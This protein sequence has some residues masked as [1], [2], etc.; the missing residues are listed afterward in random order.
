[1]GHVLGQ[2]RVK[3]ILSFSVKKGRLAHAYLFHGQAGLGKDAMAIMMAKWLNCIKKQDWGCG[4]CLS[5]HQIDR[6]IHNSFHFVIPVPNKPKSMKEDRYREILRENG[7]S[8]IK[9]SYRE[10]GFGPDINTLPIIGIDQIRALKKEVILKLP[11]DGNRVILIS[12]ADKMTISAANSLLKLLEE[13]PKGTLLFLTTAYPD[14]LL[15]TILSRCHVIRFDPIAEKDLA[16]F[17]KRKNQVTEQKANLYAQIAGGSLGKALTIAEGAYDE[18]LNAAVNFFE[19][20]LA[21]DPIEKILAV[22]ELQNGREKTELIEILQILQVWMRDI[23]MAQL[24]FM[25]RILH[26][27]QE[28][29]IQK[30]LQKKPFFHAE[31]AV[32]YVVQSIDFIEKNVYLSLII[33]ALIENIQSCEKN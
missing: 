9:D 13:P 14:R 18:K 30:L 4:E 10:V 16:C 6:I 31:E 22:E 12:H 28:G 17:L 26:K 3:E 11:G 24:G 27:E 8:R 7:L 15:P 20:A 23:Y 19:G 32:K 21:D 33:Y 1:M 2:D 29:R 25:E 5:C